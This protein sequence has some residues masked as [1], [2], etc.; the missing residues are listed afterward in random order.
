MDAYSRSCRWCSTALVRRGA[1]IS[2]ALRQLHKS[3]PASTITHEKLSA[4]TY[5]FKL[6]S[7]LSLALGIR[8]PTC[9]YIISVPLVLKRQFYRHPLFKISHERFYANARWRCGTRNRVCQHGLPATPSSASR[10]EK[11]TDSKYSTRG[12]RD[13]EIGTGRR[14]HLSARSNLVTLDTSIGTPRT[15]AYSRQIPS[16]CPPSAPIDRTLGRSGSAQNL[17]PW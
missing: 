12:T 17:L 6:W 11:S 13:V 9:L 4:N 5:N 10:G 7:P 14:S 1:E 8:M 3:R 16:K 2:H 15:R